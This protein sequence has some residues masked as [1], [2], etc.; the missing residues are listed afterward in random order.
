MRETRELEV[1]EILEEVDKT[2]TGLIAELGKTYGEMLD[3]TLDQLD[4]FTRDRLLELYSLVQRIQADLEM[5]IDNLNETIL[6]DLR[7]ATNNV[8]Q[9]VSQVEDVFVVAFRGSLLIVREAAFV[10]AFIAD[11]VLLGLGLI[12]F[13]WLLFTNRLPTQPTSRRLALGGIAL[14]LILFGM[15]ILPAPR[16]YALTWTPLGTV[17]NEITEPRIFDVNPDSLVIGK[18]Q[19]IRLRG[20][21]PRGCYL[22]GIGPRKRT[23]SPYCARWKKAAKKAQAEETGP[24]SVRTIDHHWPESRRQEGFLLPSACCLLSHLRVQR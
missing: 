2:L 15:L 6:E 12:V 3:V 9:V 23:L 10:M 4:E 5:C 24:R 20:G 1:K 22:K 18:T 21:T 19:E 17:A 7:I 11:L 8:R 16:A 13:I 14:F